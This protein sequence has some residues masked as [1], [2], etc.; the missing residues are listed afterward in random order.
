MSS[1]CCIIKFNLLA[2]LS[3]ECV[4]PQNL[5][6]QV[7]TILYIKAW[8]SSWHII[9]TDCVANMPLKVFFSW[10]RLVGW[11]IRKLRLIIST[12][13]YFNT[14]VGVR[15]LFEIAALDWLFLLCLLNDLIQVNDRAECAFFLDA[16]PWYQHFYLYLFY[17][18]KSVS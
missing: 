3:L 15:I 5:F 16:T 9:Y 13:N 2:W 7:S 14:L 4:R 10:D 11:G 17:F 12:L 1:I 6:M 8:S 18:I